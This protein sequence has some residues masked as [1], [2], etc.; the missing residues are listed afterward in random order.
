MKL[1]IGMSCY[2]DY[3]G[4]WFTIQSIKMYHPECI[5]DIR[6]V[7][8]D[9]NPES[10]HGKSC[11]KL[12][13][14]LTNKHGNNGLYVK[15]VSWPGTASREYVF[16][17]ATT[18]YVMCI[19]SH[20]LIQP[21]ALRK[22][23]DYY[24]VNPEC[25]DLLQGPLLDE[26]S[27][28]FANRMEPKWDY[29]MYGT[30]VNDT[31]KNDE[32]DPY[33]IDMMGLG[34]FAC[35]KQSWPGF[36]PD[37]RGFGGEEGYIHKKFKKQGNKTLMLPWLKWQHRFDRPN[38]VP[39][40][41][42]YIDRVKNYLIGWTE[43][44]VSTDEIK[45]YYNTPNTQPGQERPAIDMSDL[46]D[47]ESQITSTSPTHQSSPGSHQIELENQQLKERI[48]ELEIRLLSGADKAESFMNTINNIPTPAT[49]ID[50]T[51][52]TTTT[53]TTNTTM[54]KDITAPV[55]TIRVETSNLQSDHLNVNT[56]KSETNTYKPEI[57]KQSPVV[58]NFKPVSTTRSSR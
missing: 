43:L 34:L 48:I 5:D 45:E 35:R 38:G 42:E 19:D 9:G 18:P 8:I 22:L 57:F 49:A 20:V 28:P 39:Y 41:N 6:F 56:S 11:E 33:E 32:T 31:S 3:D 36:N 54:V 53:N 46:N 52:T 40:R 47:Y 1:T 23:L 51:H 29:N 13:S 21:G 25:D 15:N 44:G 30:W 55:E 37:F 2:D 4:V 58:D 50:T 24:E 10:A 16:Q 7:V 26:D 17:F 14:S 12:I 27:K